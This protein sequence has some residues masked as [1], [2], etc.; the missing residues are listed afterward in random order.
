MDANLTGNLIDLFAVMMLLLSMLAMATTRFNQLVSAFALQSLALSALAFIM[1]LSTGHLELYVV[2][3]I[4]FAVKVVIIPWFI[5]HT[6]ERMKI[7]RESDSSI[8][9]PGSLLISAG[10]ITAAYFIAEPMIVDVDVMTRDCLAIS[11]AILFIGLFMMVIHRKAMTQAIGLLT[12]E[13]GLFLG[14]LSISYGMP[15]IVELGI[16]FDVLMASV[17]IGVFALRISMMFDSSDT[18]LLRRLKD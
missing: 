4:T 3:A 11:T 14:V 9:V 15:M 10:L 12:I 7:G 8:G 5:M 6:G 16:F 13:N 18:Y 1:A 2:S 17:I